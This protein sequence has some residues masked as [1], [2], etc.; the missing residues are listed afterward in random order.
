MSR[1]F[2]QEYKHVSILEKLFTISKL[3]KSEK[4]SNDFQKY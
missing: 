2:P 3:V 4:S 1:F